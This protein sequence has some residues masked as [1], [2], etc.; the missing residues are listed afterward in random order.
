[1]PLMLVIEHAF[2]MAVSGKRLLVS[3]LIHNF[4]LTFF[5]PGL[6]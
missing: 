3:S 4:S 6:A 5:P 1:M 2:G